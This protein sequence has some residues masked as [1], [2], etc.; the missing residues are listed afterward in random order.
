MKRFEH[1]NAKTIDEAIS[2]LEKYYGKAKLIAGG[3]DLLRIL[4]DDVLPE[5]P[6]AIINLKTISGLEYIKEEDG[7]LK[8]GALTRLHDIATSPLVK[9]GYPVLAEACRS[10]GTPQIRHMGTIGGNLCQEVQCWYYRASKSLGRVF[11]C[12]RKGGDMCYAVVGDNRFHSVFGGKGCVAVCPSDAAIALTALGAWVKV[13]GPSSERTI[14]ISDLYGDLGLKLKPCEVITEINVPKPPPNAKQMW[15][16]F[17]L[18]N[19][20]DFAIVSVA[21]TLV[22]EN[23]KCVDTRIVLGGVAPAPKRAVKAEEYLVGK[24]VTEETAANAG[25]LAV[26][27]A[28]PLSHNSYKVAIAESLVKKVI[29][30]YSQG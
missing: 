8:I 12:T 30:T 19:S 9:S 27:D 22:L 29:L 24:S 11:H 1:F 13:R 10:I 23:G 20:I 4:K 28:K 21:A 2:L 17:R 14:V 15:M 26:A 16:K 5:Y 7:V 18:R 6:K 25:K 3:T